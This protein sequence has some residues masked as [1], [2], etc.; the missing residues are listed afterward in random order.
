MF[1]QDRIQ[2]RFVEQTHETLNISLAEKIAEKPVTQ[3]K[4]NTQQ[5]VNTR[6]QHVLP[7]LQIVKKTVEVPEVPVRWV[8]V[9]VV[10]GRASSTAAGHGEDSSDPTVAVGHASSTGAGRAGDS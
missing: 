10:L 9:P 4:G 5:V 6:V 2:Q 1:H 3:T 8:N 7:L